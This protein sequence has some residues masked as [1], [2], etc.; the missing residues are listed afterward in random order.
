[1]PTLAEALKEV[2]TKSDT[3]IDR[4]T[5][6]KWAGRAVAAFRIASETGDPTMILRAYD[7]EHEALEHASLVGDYGKLV[8]QIQKQIEVEKKKSRGRRGSAL[9]RLIPKAK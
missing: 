6:H 5:A 4:E 3:D 1:M 7:Y 9:H 8:G 2:R